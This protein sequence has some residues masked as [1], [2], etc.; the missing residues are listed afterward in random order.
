MLD[1]WLVGSLAR[2][3]KRMTEMERWR[4]TEREREKGGRGVSLPI[5]ERE[6]KMNI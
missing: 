6:R 1:V 5:V 2:A 3:S 4:E